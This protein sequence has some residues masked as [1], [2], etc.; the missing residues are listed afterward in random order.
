MTT[1]LQEKGI[2]S[3]CLLPLRT[4]HRRL[5]FFG[6]GSSLAD[7]Y[8]PEHVE[9][10]G[11]VAD[12]VALTIDDAFHFETL[13]LEKNR[14]KMLLDVNNAIT[15]NL[16]LPDLLRA[17]SASLRAVMRSE[18]AGV[19]LLDAATNKLRLCVIDFPANDGRIAEGEILADDS[20][21]VKSIRAGE[22][23]VCEEQGKSICHVPLMSRERV[24]GSLG[25]ARHE[26]FSTQDLNFLKQVSGQVAVAVEN[27]LAY[28]QIAELKDKL[29]R[30][31][32]YLEDEIRSELNFE[33]IVGKSQALRAIL[34]QVETVAPTDSTVLIYGETG[35]GKELIARAIHDL[36]SRAKSAF[37]KL[38]CAAIPTGL[39]ESE[40]F[41]H[42]RGAFTGAV[43]N[44]SAVSSWPAEARYFWM[45]LVKSRWNCN[46]NYCVFY[47][48]VSSSDWAARGR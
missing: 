9:F 48:S 1:A 6:V 13:Q 38:N 25:V 7:A 22:P 43:R 41:G 31:K 46:R 45:K 4:A 16:Q 19:A 15:A 30:E 39:L 29:A 35:T 40:M 21:A 5:G 37:V 28:G 36:S 18:G 23:I 17:I 10:L 2:R 11:L 24:L 34:Q 44:A 33:E 3:L 27:A 42:E 32:L 12:G 20:P 26:P 47:R 14:L 8:P